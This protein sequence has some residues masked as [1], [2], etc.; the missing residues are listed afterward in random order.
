MLLGWGGELRHGARIAGRITKPYLMTRDGDGDGE[1]DGRGRHRQNIATIAPM[2]S[3]NEVQTLHQRLMAAWNE[4]NVEAF[5]A[6]LTEDGEQIGFRRQSGLRR[7]AHHRGT[8]PILRRPRDR[9]LCRVGAS[10]GFV[11]DDVAVLRAEVGMVP[12]SGDD[13][14][15]ERNVVQCLV[16]VRTGDGWKVTLFQNTPAQFDGRPEAVKALTADL[17]TALNI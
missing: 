2:R 14:V 9:Q 8:A 4:G 12:P 13:I 11:G 6:E 1:G 10:L 15:R 16:A 3:D 5:G 17:R 7:R